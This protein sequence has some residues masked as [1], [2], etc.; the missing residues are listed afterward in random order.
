MVSNNTPLVGLVSLVVV[1]AVIAAL[2]AL[3]I[4]GSD[5]LRPNTSAAEARARDQETKLKDQ[6][7]NI[8]M[9]SYETIQTARTLAEQEKIRLEVEARQRELEQT[10]AL[11]RERAA[12]DMELAHLTHYALSVA[13]ALAVLIVSVGLTVC[14]IRFGLSRWVTAQP[15]VVYADPWH[16]H[17][18][19][20]DQIRHAHE[21]EMAERGSVLIWRTAQ[22]PTVRGNGRHPPEDK[23]IE[24]TGLKTVR[25]NARS[26]KQ[27]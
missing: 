8:D 13:A 16:D 18:W 9:K 22:R 2:G 6:K 1:I 25:A 14:I 27:Q 4:S 20:T 15:Q 23:P 11:Q 7:A 19:R 26:A 17:A 5:I 12:Q 10:L 21:I 3:G 24:A